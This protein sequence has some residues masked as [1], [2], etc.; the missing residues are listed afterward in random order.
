M[1]RNVTLRFLAALVL[2]AFLARP[3]S[4]QP[5]AKIDPQILKEI[6]ELEL[7]LKKLQDRLKGIKDELQK[8][9]A[10]VSEQPAHLDKVLAWRSIGP[11][12]MGGR[13]T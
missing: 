13:I 10:P 9:L 1:S 3:G 5:P 2:F 7:R 8:P 11:A 6:E 4:A 12:N